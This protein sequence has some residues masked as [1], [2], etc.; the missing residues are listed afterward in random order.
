M[1]IET[2]IEKKRIAP[3]GATLDACQANY[4]PHLRS[5]DVVP[6]GVYKHFASPELRHRKQK[7]STVGL[8]NNW[9]CA[10]F[11]HR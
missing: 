1:F 11:L 10:D 4:M 6:N 2:D 3:L 8:N 5:S 9:L 7:K